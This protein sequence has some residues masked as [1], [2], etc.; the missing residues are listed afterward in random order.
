MANKKSSIDQSLI[1]DLAGILNET[2]LSEIEVE[3]DDL[4]IRISRNTSVQHVQ[5]QSPAASPAPAAPAPAAAVQTVTETSESKPAGNVTS[6]MVGTAYLSPA[7][8]A[9]PFVSVGDSVKAGDTVLIV[10][11]MKT[12]NQIPAP[13]SGTV[14]AILVEDGQ[15]VEFGEPLL[16][17]E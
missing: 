2:D 10:E 11:A 9:D 13:N 17:I 5:V 8:G 6:P 7:P 16:L 3:Q 12:M 1:R 4:R 15:P 14:K